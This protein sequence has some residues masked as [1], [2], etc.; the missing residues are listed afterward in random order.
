MTRKTVAFESTAADFGR[1][2]AI[3]GKAD[4]RHGLERAMV[5]CC[6]MMLAV[7]SFMIAAFGRQEA[8]RIM[9]E[10]VEGIISKTGLN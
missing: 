3:I 7:Q 8:A 5:V 4:K 1:F 6:S 9:Q 2:H 10:F